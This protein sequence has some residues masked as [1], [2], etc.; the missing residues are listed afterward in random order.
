MKTFYEWIKNEQVKTP[1]EHKNWLYLE[2]IET[3][4]HM[5]YSFWRDA[6]S[7]AEDLES[8]FM[9][10]KKIE[11]MEREL[12]DDEYVDMRLS[13]DFPYKIVRMLG[14]GGEKRLS[15]RIRDMLDSSELANSRPDLYWGEYGVVSRVDAL[16]DSIDVATRYTREYSEFF[17]KKKS[18]INY[19][20]IEKADLSPEGREKVLKLKSVYEVVFNYIRLL[21]R[22]GRAVRSLLASRNHKMKASY[23]GGDE[24]KILPNTGKVE[25]LYHA[26]PYVREIIREGFKTK[27]QLGN[28]QSLGGDTS[29]GI[30]FTADLRVAREIAKCFV[31]VI[32]IAKGKMTVNDVLRLIRSEKKKG[33]EPW[34]LKDY[35]NKARQRQWKW[36]NPHSRELSKRTGI[37]MPGKPYDINDKKE[38]FDLYRRYLSW[39][40]KRYDPLF[41]GTDL[42]SFE[43][44]EEVNVG[45]VAAKVDMTKVIGYHYSMEEYRVPIDAILSIHYKKQTKKII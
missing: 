34:A 17:H 39:S 11:E 5:P 1:E 22:V 30:S 20:E 15:E 42:N 28:R 10:M 3:P 12:E 32:R 43:S 9:P 37:P 45:V 26:T 36:S 38:A 23:S 33:E 16:G 19:G 4:P 2:R 7:E 14:E 8:K 18:Y 25:V 29:G 6:M 35:I 27:E 44:L 21:K 31:E 13:R 40:D 41:F 24:T